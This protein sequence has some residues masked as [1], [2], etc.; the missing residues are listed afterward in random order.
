[1]IPADLKLDLCSMDIFK[2]N[3]LA[4]QG[5]T[6]IG[7]SFYKKYFY[8]E[9]ITWKKYCLHFEYFS[10]SED[11][12]EIH[13]VP[14]LSICTKWFIFSF[15]LLIEWINPIKSYVFGCRRIFLDSKFHSENFWILNFVSESKIHFEKRFHKIEVL[16]IWNKFR[17]NC[18]LLLNWTLSCPQLS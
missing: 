15:C 8:K 16:E 17:N 6:K 7:F 2:K 4:P 10:D 18:L 5:I 14:C 12:F 13:A 9:I 3:L 11:N 1:M